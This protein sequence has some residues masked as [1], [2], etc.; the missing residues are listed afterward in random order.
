MYAISG[1][2]KEL[3]VANYKR[4]K[5][6]LSFQST[7]FAS[8]VYQFYSDRGSKSTHVYRSHRPF[9]LHVNCLLVLLQEHL[10]VY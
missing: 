6:V 3:E 9:K 2:G 8:F 10:I 7:R 1:K 5:Q 4:K